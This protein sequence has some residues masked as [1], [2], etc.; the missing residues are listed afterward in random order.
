MNDMYDWQLHMST[1]HPTERAKKAHLEVVVDAL[2]AEALGDHHH[3][4]LYVEA[5]RHLGAALLILPPDGHQQLVFQQGR[6]F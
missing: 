3:P 4:A 6:T 1:S 2:W 5:Q